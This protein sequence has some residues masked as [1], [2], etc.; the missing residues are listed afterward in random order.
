MDTG[1]VSNL[2]KY[3]K[4]KYGKVLDYLDFGSL[5]SRKWQTIGIIGSSCSGA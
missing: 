4:D 3:F 5:L 2:F 1:K